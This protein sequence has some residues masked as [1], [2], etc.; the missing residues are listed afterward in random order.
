MQRH[1]H[2]F[3]RE[4]FDQFDKTG[5]GTRRTAGQRF[6]GDQL[7]HGFPHR[8]I[9]V[10]CVFTNRFD[11]FFANTASRDVNHPLQ[12]SIIPTA[13]KQTQVGHGVLDLG[14]FEEA[15]A[16]INPIRNA[17]AQQRLFQYP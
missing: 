8:H 12:C 15:L 13:F 5:N 17:F 7:A 2:D 6:I 3:C 10:T 11:G 14:A 16:A 1:L 9:I 4:A